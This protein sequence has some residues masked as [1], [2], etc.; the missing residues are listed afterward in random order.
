MDFLNLPTKNQQIYW[1]VYYSFR[2]QSLWACS[3]TVQKCFTLFRCFIRCWIFN[4]IEHFNPTWKNHINHQ[5]DRLLFPQHWIQREYAVM[6]ERHEFL[7]LSFS[8]VKQWW[9]QLF[10]FYFHLVHWCGHWTIWEILSI[11]CKQMNWF[12]VRAVI[13]IS[14]VLQEYI[15]EFLLVDFKHFQIYFITNNHSWVS[16]F[17]ALHRAPTENL[18]CSQLLVA[19]ELE[20]QSLFF[21]I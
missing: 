3:F 18:S 17:A 6:K 9:K 2:W 20:C 19:L 15:D 13:V 5:S 8:A 14:V 10:F 21:E 11:P 1:F 12:G 16:V 7:Q 4:S